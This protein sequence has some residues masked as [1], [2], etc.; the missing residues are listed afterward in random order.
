MTFGVPVLIFGKKKPISSGLM[1]PFFEWQMGT[2]QSRKLGRK[3]ERKEEKVSSVKNQENSAYEEKFYAKKLLSF[4]FNAASNNH[5][6]FA[7]CSGL[8]TGAAQLGSH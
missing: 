5:C 2:D 8:Y 1:K 7:V 6:F 3:D 4:C